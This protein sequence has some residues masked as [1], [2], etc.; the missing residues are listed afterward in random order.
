MA[1]SIST[2]S[3]FQSLAASASRR[4]MHLL[5]QLAPL[6]LQLSD[7][8]Q[9]PPSTTPQAFV[10]HFENLLVPFKWMAD[11]LGL[12][13]TAQGIDAAQQ[14]Y[15]QSTDLQ[16]AL[17]VIEDAV[18]QL[19]QIAASLGPVFLVSD[20]TVTYVE[21]FCSVFFPR[22]TAF[23][24][25]ATGVI[26]VMGASTTSLSLSGRAVWKIEAL[27]SICTEKLFTGPLAG[28][29]LSHPQTGRFAL[30]SLNAHD[31]D[32]IAATKAQQEVAP[33]ALL[34]MVKVAST[35]FGAMELEQFHAQL[36]TLTRFVLEATKVDAPIS[37]V[38]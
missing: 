37:H 5:E 29:L 23:L 9:P 30:V 16:L 36:E 26:H 19:L 13:K 33:F 27:R 11:R 17:R 3:L 2:A 32:A 12:N 18:L 34:K 6:L 8:P 4:H 10:I 25:E 7:A 24:R 1:S 21:V 14:T 28:E 38:L 22:L 20:A 15:Q 31:M 35:S